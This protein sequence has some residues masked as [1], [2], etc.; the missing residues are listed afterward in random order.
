KLACLKS[1]P[2]RLARLRLARVKSAN[3]NNADLS[4]AN[5]RNAINLTVEQ[6]K[7][8]NNWDKAEYDPEFKQELGLDS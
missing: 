5:L 2:S 7:A 6:V 8:A 3:L 1:A 4:H